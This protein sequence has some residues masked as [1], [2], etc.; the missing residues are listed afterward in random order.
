MKKLGLLV[1]LLVATRVGQC[2]TATAPLPDS[3]Q[4]FL[5]KSLTLLETYSL[6]RGAVNW[7]QLRQQVQQKA[8]GAQSVR[9]LL[10]IYPFVFEQLKDDHGWLSYQGKTYKWRNTARP[11]YTNTAVKAALAKKP[12]VLVKMLSG[13][14]GYV[15]L[16][17]INAGGSLQAM[18]DAALVVQDSLCR[19]NPNKA[20]AW[21]IDLRLN[22]GGAMAPMLAGLAPIIGDGYLGGFVDKDGKPDQQWYLKHGNFYMDTLQVTTLQNRCPM[23]RPNI[24]VAVLL[25]GMTASSGEIVAISLKG[26]PNTRF[27]GE[28]TYGAT[29]ANES[30]RISGSSYLTI[31][32]M[33]ETD[34]N[35]VVYRPNVV[36]DVL[37]TGGDNFTDLRQDAKVAAALKWLKKQKSR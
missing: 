25:S 3:V 12:G 16:P 5:D 19:V 20:K 34:R 11:V 33:Q 32:G 14:V 10:P 17:G 13:N 18:R 4:A 23:R 8:Q 1:L 28:P 7:P 6:E 36:P 31:A 35:K 30:Y 27:F 37:I 22:D 26:R 9:E 15:Q 21:V 24:P 29:T 2:Q